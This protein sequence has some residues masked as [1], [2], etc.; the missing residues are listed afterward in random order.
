MARLI[1]LA[2][3]LPGI[4]ISQPVLAELLVNRCQRWNINFRHGAKIAD[5]FA[6]TK[7]KHRY[8]LQKPWFP[9][10]ESELSQLGAS[11]RSGAGDQEHYG[12]G[13]EQT[14]VDVNQLYQATRA[15][16][17][18]LASQSASLAISQVPSLT[19]GNID[20]AILVSEM[21]GC[22]PLG[23]KFW[24][25][26]GIKPSAVRTSLIGLGCLGGAE[27]LS[28]A[29]RHLLAYPSDT[30]LITTVEESSAKWLTQHNDQLRDIVNSELQLDQS[31]EA[32]RVPASPAYLAQLD[33]VRYRLMNEIVVAALMGSASVSGVIVGPNSRYAS[34]QGVELLAFRRVAFGQ[35]DLVGSRV[36]KLGV[37]WHMS[38][39]IADEAAP[40]AVALIK[41]LLADHGLTW[42]EVIKVCHPGGPKVLKKIQE[43]SGSTDQDLR[44]SWNALEIGNCMSNSLLLALQEA[45][46]DPANKGRY[47]VVM[48]VG[49]GLGLAM[50]V[51]LVRFC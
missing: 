45:M 32:L 46:A 50:E 40:V 43:L 2:K 7:V 41:Q 38:S 25:G 34:N 19:T 10:E 51:G 16:M 27:G 31:P 30:V 6:N 28:A 36:D 15:G 24:P 29:H 42:A 18:Q 20:A 9:E 17:V 48:G 39:R 49:P 4:K 8:F 1:S 14:K 12:L 22:G 13:Y 33:L 47:G 5:I 11:G 37:V 21:P 26:F 23:N 44:Y 3:A 35:E